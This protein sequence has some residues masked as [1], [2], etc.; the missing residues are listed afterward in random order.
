M[1]TDVAR[2]I[3][4]TIRPETRTVE[5]DS[6]EVEPTT[7]QANVVCQLFAEF[8][9]ARP[10]EF[11]E[12]LEFMKKGDWAMEWAAAG[13]GCAY[14]SFFESGTPLA[15]V[16]LLCGYQPREEQLMLDGMKAAILSR[17]LGPDAETLMHLPDRPGVLQVIF[18][19]SPEHGPTIQLLTSALASVYFRA[20]EK[21]LDRAIAEQN[22]ES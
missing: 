22:E 6:F 9:S 2:F 3:V 14:A 17:M 12:P 15:M 5:T 7:Q 20:M 16:V 13:G 19:G 4:R 21:M 18:P 11:K 8:L 10:T 1:S